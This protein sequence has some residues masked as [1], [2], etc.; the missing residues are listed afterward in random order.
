MR[1]SMVRRGMRVVGKA[2]LE[3]SASTAAEGLMEGRDRM[4]EIF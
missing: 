2:L 3:R 1:L 4:A